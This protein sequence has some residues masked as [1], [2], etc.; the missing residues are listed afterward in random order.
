MKA[1]EVCISHPELE[2][3]ILFAGDRD[4]IDLVTYMVQKA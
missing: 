4:F 3:V 2:T 1:M